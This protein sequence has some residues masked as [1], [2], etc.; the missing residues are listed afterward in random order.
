[1]REV[2]RPCCTCGQ[3]IPINPAHWGND[4]AAIYAAAIECQPCIESDDE[5]E[6]DAD[7]EE[8]DAAWESE[9]RL[10]L[11]EGWQA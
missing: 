9:R 3:P 8:H 11:M 6:H 5:E 10:R 1:M 7:G 2:I 4:L